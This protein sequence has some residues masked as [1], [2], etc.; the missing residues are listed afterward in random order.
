MPVTPSATATPRT[1]IGTSGSRRLRNSGRIPGNIYG[2]NRPAVSISFVTTEIAPIVASGALVLD[3]NVSGEISKAIIRE[4]QWDTFFTKLLH[5]DL[6][7]VDP[8]LRVAIVVQVE[9]RGTPASGVLDQPVRSIALTCPAYL[10]P[11]VVS[12]RVGTLVIGDSIT[13][14]QLELP[15]GVVCDLPGTIVVARV[16]E[17]RDPAVDQFSSGAVEPELIAKGKSAKT[18]AE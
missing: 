5:V 16:H 4:A 8:A 10:I 1:N 3:V 7:R 6:Q 11:E 12:I 13:V 15:E 2:L 9:A 17:P 18:D 14:S